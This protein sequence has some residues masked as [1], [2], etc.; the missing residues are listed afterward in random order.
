[1]RR[2]ELITEIKN[3]RESKERQNGDEMRVKGRRRM[4]S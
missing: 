3:K 2:K 4:W 1:M